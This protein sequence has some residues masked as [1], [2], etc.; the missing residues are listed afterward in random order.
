MRP[1]AARAP[2]A[3]P[4]DGAVTR[5]VPEG[6]VVVLHEPNDLVNVALVI[7]AMKNMGL[8]RLRV[9]RPAEPLDP[10]RLEGIAHGTDDLIARLERFESLNEAIADAAWV[11]GSSARRRS[12]RQQWWTPADAAP[13]ILDRAATGGVA[14]L[15]G[16][17]DRGL[18]NE[19]LDRCHAVISVPTSPEHPSLNLAH[20]ALLVFYELRLER[21]RRG[22]AVDRDLSSKQRRTT[23]PASAEELERFFE[24]WQEAM[25]TVGLFH[26]IDPLPKMRTFRTI[27]QRAELDRREL[28]LLEA[29]AYEV[30]HYAERERA[31]ARQRLEGSTKLRVEPPEGEAPGRDAPEGDACDPDVPDGG[32]QAGEV[33]PG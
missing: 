25:E 10:Y 20:A 18:S 21:L 27:F 2:E 7:R 12:S 5:S 6:L 33:P 14:L 11:L 1:A 28:G 17:E 29:A 22:E 30:I 16:P 8:S 15:F 9:V 32:G 19:E 26:G 4:E 31:R 13:R 3:V 24:V 23:P